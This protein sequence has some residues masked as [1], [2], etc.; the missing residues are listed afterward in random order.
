M[1]LTLPRYL[2]R[3]YPHAYINW[4]VAAKCSQ[5]APLFLNHPD[6][7]R[8]IISDS[9]GYGP[10]ELEIAKT[11]DMVFNPLPQHPEG[12]IWPN[13][14]NIY[15]ETWVMASAPLEVYHSLPKEDQVPHLYKWFKNERRPKSVAIWP[16]ARQG[17]KQKRNPDW[18]WWASLCARLVAEGYTVYQCGHPNDL[19]GK[20]PLGIDV[21]NQSFMDLIALSLGCDFVMGTDSGSMVALAAYGLTNTISLLCPHWPN[22]VENPLAFGPLGPRHVNLWAAT[23]NGHDVEK[24]L[25]AMRQFG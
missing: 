4:V 1:A 5:A 9:E 24:V 13:R 19:A 3:V 15:E 16:G 6:I 12:D 2:K 14:R 25:D 23:H 22:H 17:E 18:E 8:I 10:N 11:C 21:R 20:P 7:D